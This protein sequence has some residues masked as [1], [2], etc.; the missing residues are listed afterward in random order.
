MNPSAHD[1][2]LPPE[3][4]AAAVRWL[5]LRDGGRMTPAEEREFEAWLEADE[6]HVAAFAALDR[7]WE[8]FDTLTAERP[9]GAVDPDLLKRR[10]APVVRPKWRRYL[11]VGLAAAAAVAAGLFVWQPWAPALLNE[12]A[13]TQIGAWETKKLPD[14][15]QIQLNT[16][17]LVEVNYGETERRVK[18]VRGEAHFIVAKNKARPFIVTAGRVDVRAVGTAFD[19]RFNPSAV[20]VLVTEGRVR[21][22][23]ADGKSLLASLDATTP[24]EMPTL[25]AGHR[26]IIPVAAA[27]VQPEPVVATPLAPAEMSRALAWQEQR[28]EFEDV[29][30]EQV[31]AEFNRYNTHKLVIEGETLKAQRFGGK[32]RPDGYDGL[33]SLLEKSFEVSVERQD[34]RTVLRTKK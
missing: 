12:T 15:S 28:L 7:M 22:D 13:V 18:L 27:E 2:V 11:P 17:T 19:V 31:I 32:F 4:E 3:I 29:P 16:D 23:D 6:R 5:G 34:G 24:S 9:P 25:G 20:E 26:V 8:K 1:L 30:L 10:L 21:V 14:G 33:V